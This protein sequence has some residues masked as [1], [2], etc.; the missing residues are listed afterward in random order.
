MIK[1]DTIIFFFYDLSLDPRMKF[2]II[3]KDSN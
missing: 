3:N 2:S 1:S